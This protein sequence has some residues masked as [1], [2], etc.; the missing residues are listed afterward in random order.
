MP[1][2]VKWTEPSGGMF[3]FVTL[4]PSLDAAKLLEKSISNNVA[5]VSGSAFYCNNEG[6]NTMRM[7]FSF[8]D[9]KDICEGIKRL[10]R[11]IREELASA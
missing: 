9:E 7:N 4:P 2:G 6:H 1:E 5:F 11:V 8:A 3:L 10:S